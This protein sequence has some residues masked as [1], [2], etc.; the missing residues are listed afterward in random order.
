MQWVSIPVAGLLSLAPSLLG[1]VTAF[2][3]QKPLLLN[4]IEDGEETANDEEEGNVLCFTWTESNKSASELEE[5]YI[6]S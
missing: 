5:E 3:R 4:P 2:T 6:S 1:R